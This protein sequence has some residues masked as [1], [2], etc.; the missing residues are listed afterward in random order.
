M[1]VR[2]VELA[3]RDEGEGLPLVW[4]HGLMGSMAQEDAA[5]ML[6]W[7]GLGEG[8]RLIRYDARGHGL[9]EATLSADAYRWPKLADGLWE[10]ADGLGVERGVLGGV[11]MGAAIALHAA[12]AAPKRLLG[13]VLMAPPTAWSSRPRQARVYRG[14]ARLVDW[15]GIR[16]FRYLG[17]VAS[18]AVRNRGLAAMQRSVMQGLGRADPR[19][20]RAA[21]HGAAESDLP[22]TERVREIFSPVL[23]LA[24]RHDPTHPVSTAEQLHDL[25]PNSELH[26][27]GSFEDIRAWAG[28][29]RNFLAKCADL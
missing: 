16:S 20:V 8:V 17:A 14:S 1:R 12:V 21:L 27:A 2:G 10:L 11:S 19:A 23:I 4:G 15:V 9:S 29:L 24:W 5:G 7:E 6:P 28:V 3:V 18:L 26:V 13:L 22:D 25:L